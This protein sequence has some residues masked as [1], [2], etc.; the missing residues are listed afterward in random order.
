MHMLQII[1]ATICT[2]GCPCNPNSPLR[3]NSDCAFDNQEFESDEAKM[4]RQGLTFLNKEKEL[5]RLH[6]KGDLLCVNFPPKGQ[7][8][9]FGGHLDGF[10]LHNGKLMSLKELLDTA[11]SGH[12]FKNNFKRPYGSHQSNAI[13]DVNNGEDFNNEREGGWGSLGGSWG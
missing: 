2:P 3:C 1:P 12:T 4:T 10:I 7:V 8:K 9:K 5:G 6:G 13:Y 11:K